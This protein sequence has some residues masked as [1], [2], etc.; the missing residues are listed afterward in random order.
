LFSFLDPIGIFGGG[1]G[2]SASVSSTMNLNVNGLD[3]MK[4]TLHLDP[5]HVDPL[6]L[7]LNDNISL[8]VKQPITVNDNI[9]LDVKQPITVND[10]IGLDVKPLTVSETFDL[11][12]VAVDACQTLRLAPLPETRV[13][14]PYRH[15]VGYTLLG[16]EW[17]GVTY[18]GESQQ[19]VESPHRPQVVDRPSHVHQR[20][21]AAPTEIVG[22]RG[23]RVR[24]LNPDD[25]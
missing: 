17:M 24:V 12:P 15:H 11:R 14:Q 5:V 7:T 6:Q 3:N 16:I 8:D 20:R 23:I 19:V 10:N 25:E 2:G 1:G 13:C 22:S 21:P 18:E 9:S 4:S